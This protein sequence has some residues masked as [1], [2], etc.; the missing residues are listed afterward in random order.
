MKHKMGNT[1]K[2]IDC[3]W[4]READ[5]PEHKTGGWCQNRKVCSTG[6]N[7]H[8]RDH[9]LERTATEWNGCCREWE[10]AEDHVTGYEVLCGVPEPWRTEEEQGRI[11]ELLQKGR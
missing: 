2:C 5:G 8:K 10:D 9:P 6:I 4:Y 1:P 7:G 3:A 11:R